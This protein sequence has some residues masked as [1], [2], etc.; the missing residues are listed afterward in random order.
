MTHSTSTP[1][2][3]STG[4]ASTT[5]RSRSERHSAQAALVRYAEDIASLIAR[6]SRY[7]SRNDRGAIDTPLFAN[8]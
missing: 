1:T 3:T 7:D 5:V 6:D 2:A 4:A 8:V